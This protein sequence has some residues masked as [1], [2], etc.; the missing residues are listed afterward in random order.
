MAD[1]AISALASY[2]TVHSDDLLL[3]VDV[4]DT[5]MAVAGTDK[6]S[7]VSVLL[8]GLTGDVTYVGLAGTIAANAVTTSK[9]N[10]S[11]V[12]YAKIQNVSVP[13]LL[14]STAGG[15]APIEISLGANLSFVG[16]SLVAAGGSGVTS[17]SVGNGLTGGP[18]TGTGTLSIAA[19]TANTLAGFNSAGA[20]A[21]VTPGNGLSLVAGNLTSSASPTGQ[22][23][24]Q[25]TSPVTIDAWS[26][27]TTFNLLLADNHSVTL[28]G[29]TTYAFSNAASGQ[30][31]S[32]RSTQSATGTYAVTW[33]ATITWFTSSFS[34]PPFP[35]SLSGVQLCSFKYNGNSQYDGFWCGNSSV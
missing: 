4:H 18:I 12:T 6:K 23:I 15:T 1:T 28:L 21:G 27:T 3:V 31:F 24:V 8:G 14:G 16:S 26:A 5:S 11:A 22:S 19:S 7:T 25:H 20:F 13:A 10:N 32:I 35:A 29:N 34:A 2:V 9:I 30:P 17:V 33:P